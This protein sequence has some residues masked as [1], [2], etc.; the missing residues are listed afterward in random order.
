MTEPGSSGVKPV[1]LH[2]EVVTGRDN[3]HPVLQFALTSPSGRLD[4]F[5]LKGESGRLPPDPT[6]LAGHLLQDLEE[7]LEGFWDEATQLQ[8]AEVDAQLRRIGKG[9]YRFLLPESLRL[10]FDEAGLGQDG[11]LLVETDETWIPWELLHTLGKQGD[12]L[13]MRYRMSRWL[14]K[15]SPP[16]ASL[17]VRHMVCIDAGRPKGTSPRWRPLRDSPRESQVLYELAERFPGLEIDPDLTPPRYDAVMKLLKVGGFQLLHFIGHGDF[18]ETQSAERAALVLEGR[19]LTAID[20]VDEVESVM[21]EERPFIFLNACR[22][23]RQGQSLAGFGGWPRTFVKI[24]GCGGFLA[25]QWSV[26]SRRAFEFAR[27]F[28]GFLEDG[29]SPDEEGGALLAEAVRQARILPAKARADA[30]VASPQ[31][32]LVD[33]TTLAYAFYGHPNARISWGDGAEAAVGSGDVR[34]PKD[35]EAPKGPKK[36]R[37]TRGF[38]A[39]GARL[40][41]S[42]LAM[43]LLLWLALGN[44]RTATRVQLD[45]VVDRVQFTVGGEGRSQIL[46][47]ALGLS[48]LSLSRFSR[49]ELVP[50]ASGDGSMEMVTDQHSRPALEQVTLTARDPSAFVSLEIEATTA[51]PLRALGPIG[52][53]PGARVVVQTHAAGNDSVDLSLR[54]APAEALDIPVEG[55]LDLEAEFVQ[56]TG[57]DGSRDDGLSWRGRLAKPFVTVSSG[58]EGLE[59]TATVRASSETLLLDTELPITA[60]AFLRQGTGGKYETTLKD[61]SQLTYPEQRWSGSVNLQPQDFLAVEDLR[62]FRVRR[63]G[64]DP[65]SGTLRILLEGLAGSIRA[66]PGGLGEEYS[67]TL[68]QKLPRPLWAWLVG[69]FALCMASASGL[70]SLWWMRADGR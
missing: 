36:P 66:G 24:C 65:V 51:G 49:V 59:L 68:H 45:L 43:G 70:L 15:A 32:P 60:V 42:A 61:V 22:A 46:D 54:I 26:D 13:C 8:P 56:V 55:V 7:L 10:A 18:S 33:P 3:G 37:V 53:R 23:A 34:Q 14:S 17:G 16:A 19:Y 50:F 69:W 11:S 2:L 57:I 25:P 28:Y 41:W 62:A 20:L 67:L 30:D 4:T 27:K 6:L 39:H 40:G 47:T 44:V 58:D 1:D 63:I 12:F 48:R 52:V 5:R 38:Q 9:L 35:P 21:K 64:V 29:V 31:R